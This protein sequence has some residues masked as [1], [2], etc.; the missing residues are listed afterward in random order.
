MRIY[1]PRLG[2]FLS[3]DPLIKKFAWY[4]PYQFAGN[5]P[6]AAIDLDGEEQKIM[7]NW[8]DVNGNVTR[9]RI[10]KFDFDN[11]NKLYNSLKAGLNEN[12]TYDLE[13]TKF[14]STNAQFATGFETYKTGAG[15]KTGAVIRPNNGLLKFD[16][17]A[18][19]ENGKQLVKI[20]FDNAPINEKELYIDALRGLS[21]VTN[22]LGTAVEGAGYIASVIPGGQAVGVPLIGI[23]KGVS[24][25]GDGADIGADLL[26]GKKKDALIKVGVAAV[27]VATSKAIQKIPLKKLGKEAIDTYVGRGVGAIKDGYFENGTQKVEESD[28]L[29]LKIETK[30]N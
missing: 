17:G 10:I 30:K 14:N 26:E 23:G 18:S 29:D 13:G 12:V 8:Y 20:S 9:T 15:T 22:V 1:D 28:K 11:V 25:L 24:L 27:G 4:S 6:I 21:K 16:I 2:K 3:A 5:T 7:I 19:D